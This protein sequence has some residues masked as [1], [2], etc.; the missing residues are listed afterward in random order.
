MCGAYDKVERRC[1]QLYDVAKRTRDD[2]FIVLSRLTLAQLRLNQERAQDAVGL[3]D[4]VQGHLVRL[5]VPVNV[6]TTYATY[7]AAYA[8]TGAHNDAIAAAEWAL[9]L[10][11]E[12][13]R[14]NPLLFSLHAYLPEVFLRLYEQHPDQPELLERAQQLLSETKRFKRAVPL[15]RA[16]LLGLEAK[17]ALLAGDAAAAALLFQRS[18]KEAASGGLLPEEALAAEGLCQL[19]QLSGVERERWREIACKRYLALG[20]QA[21]ARRVKQLS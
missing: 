3:L 19:S 11:A 4:A 9:E 17:A 6:A 18:A 5:Q 2:D 15:A 10:V 21:A 20:N 14:S 1:D 13:D 12:K 16:R 8:A 7:A